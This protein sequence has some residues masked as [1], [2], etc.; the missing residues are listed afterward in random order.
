[1]DAHLR[2]SA[3]IYIG[4]ANKNLP[5]AAVEALC[6]IQLDGKLV[7][8]GQE[9]PQSNEGPD[10]QNAHFNGFFRNL[11]R[12]GLRELSE[13]GPESCVENYPRTGRW[14]LD[15]PL[16]DRPSKNLSRSR[17]QELESYSLRRWGG[18]T[19]K[20][21]LHLKFHWSTL[22]NRYSHG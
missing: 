5:R 12:E 2:A 11:T 22:R 3:A 17:A 20:H 9:V 13:S 15:R 14:G 7:I 21:C 19:R 8:R 6:F 18:L 16:K 10:H 4:P 1:M